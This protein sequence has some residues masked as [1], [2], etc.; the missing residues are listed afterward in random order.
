M[1]NKVVNL[2]DLM[3]EDEKKRALERFKSRM[4]KTDKF[5]RNR[6]NNEVYLIAEFGSYYGWDGVMAI[7]NNEI[8]L[9]EVYLYLEASRKVEYARLVERTNATRIAMESANPFAKPNEKTKFYKDSM[10]SAVEAAKV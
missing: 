6:I 8:T 7:R 3:S 4:E 9:E 1:K 10:K 2:L 5:A